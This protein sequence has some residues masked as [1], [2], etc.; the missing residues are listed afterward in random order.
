MSGPVASIGVDVG[1]TNTELGLLVGNV[2]RHTRH[3]PTRSY[4]AREEV[5][6]DILGAVRS[7]KAEA[8]NE[9]VSVDALG[10]GVPATLDLSEGRTLVMPNFAGGWRGFGIVDCLE[11]A[12]GLATALINDAR[13]FVLAE[14]TLGAGRGYRDVF[15]LVLGT[16]VGGGVVLGGRVHFGHGALAGEIGHHI[17]EPHGL[18]CGCGGIG[19]LETVASAPALV[20]GVARAYLHGRSPVLHAL[21]DGSLNAVTA[22]TIVKAAG[23]GD[24]ACREAVERAAFYLGVATANVITLLAPQCIVLGGGL[25]GASE[26]I[27]SGIKETWQ[28]HLRVAGGGLPEFRVAELEHG[29]MLGAALYARQQHQQTQHQGGA[30]A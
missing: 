2:L 26:F 22:K 29:G 30:Y 17:V 6:S 13:A 27:F 5:V 25:S 20:A 23:A 10:I 8:E 19:C 18:R 21:T 16:G 14:S 7:L 1:G 9:G 28:T 11:E 15:G 3:F 4:R 24:A 12:T